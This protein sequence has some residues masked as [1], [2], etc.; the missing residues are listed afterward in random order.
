MPKADCCTALSQARKERDDA[1][2]ERD[3]ILTFLQDLGWAMGASRKVSFHMTLE[4]VE[5]HVLYRNLIDAMNAKDH[6]NRLRGMMAL[7]PRMGDAALGRLAPPEPKPSR[8]QPR[9]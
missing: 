3:F 7:A 8:L 6:V 2:A 9:P 1:I 5:A 4:G